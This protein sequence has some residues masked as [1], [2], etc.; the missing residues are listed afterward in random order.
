MA[1]YKNKTDKFYQELSKH[2][3]RVKSL[4]SNSLRRF[5]CPRG[6]EIDMALA[7]NSGRG[8]NV[9]SLK[10]ILTK[11]PINV[12]CEKC[13]VNYMVC[14]RGKWDAQCNKKIFDL[15]KSYHPELDSEEEL[16]GAV[17]K[18]VAED[19]ENNGLIHQAI[20]NID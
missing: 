13:Q 14:L 5:N 12:Y 1:I 16:K 6:H 15:V 9:A 20:S 11:D 19:I 18:I 7:I 3:G 2:F 8:C 17:I 10:S 4:K